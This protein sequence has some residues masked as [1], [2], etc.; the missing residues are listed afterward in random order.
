MVIAALAG[1]LLGSFPTAALVGRRL[2]ID[3]TRQGDNNAGWW[4]MRALAGERIA[5]VVLIVD[6]LKGAAAAAVG[7]VLWGPW[8]VAYVA[9]GAA[10]LGHAFPVFAGFRGGR[11][12]LT[13]VGGVM[14]IAPLPTGLAMGIGVLT[15]LVV[16]SGARGAQV[17][18]AAF[19]VTQLF[20]APRAHVAATGVLMTFI[21]FRF[22]AASAASRR[23]V[24]RAQSPVAGTT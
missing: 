19:P 8:W 2:G 12:V 5:V 13:F 17:A 24:V 4:N 7:F 22:A 9:V 21:G 20:F 3:P 23:Q 6:V 14:I 1:Y 18:M 10:M 11:S 16:R 15:G